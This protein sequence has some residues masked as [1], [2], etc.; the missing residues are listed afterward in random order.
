MPP[1]ISLMQS[2]VMKGRHIQFSFC[3]RPIH[4]VNWPSATPL[5]N[6]LECGLRLA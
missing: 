4:F 5:G 1:S 2:L 6:S 3:T